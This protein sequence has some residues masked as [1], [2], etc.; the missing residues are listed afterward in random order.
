[1][2]LLKSKQKFIL[3]VSVDDCIKSQAISP[4]AGKIGDS[5]SR[6]SLGSSLSPSEKGFFEGDAVIMLDDV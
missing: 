3:P 6:I 4:A 1:M 5:N 2:Q